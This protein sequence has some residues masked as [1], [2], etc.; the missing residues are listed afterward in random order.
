MNIKNVKKWVKALESGKYKQGKNCLS[1]EKDELCCLGVVCKLAGMKPRNRGGDIFF[2]TEHAYLPRKARRW[3]GID[4]EDPFIGEE[5]AADW[6]DEKDYSFK[7]IAK[8][9]RKHWL[10]Q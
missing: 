7:Q 4:D 2:G 8:E 1:N 5:R 10:K 6:N 9:I 3:L